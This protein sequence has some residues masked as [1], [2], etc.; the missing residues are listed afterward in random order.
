MSISAKEHVLA[1][2]RWLFQCVFLLVLTVV[3]VGVSGE[4]Q[5]V[6]AQD[7]DDEK[8][9]NKKA[10]N[11]KKSDTESSKKS[12]ITTST[13]SGS[14][15]TT[16]V[17]SKQTTEQDKKTTASSKQTTE[18]DKKTTA[19]SKQTTEQDKKTAVSSKQTTEQDKKTTVSSKQT[20]EQE[21]SSQDPSGK[22]KPPATTS[23]AVRA[24]EISDAE[25]ASVANERTEARVSSPDDVITREEMIKMVELKNS[26]PEDESHFTEFEDSDIAD[27][28]E[29]TISYNAD[30][31]ITSIAKSRPVLEN[32][33]FKQ[34]NESEVSSAN[35]TDGVSRKETRRT[36][37]DDEGNIRVVL[38]TDRAG[39]ET[40]KQFDS[41][42]KQTYQEVRDKDGNPIAI[43][44]DFERNEEI[45]VQNSPSS[46]R[47]TIV[48]GDG[49][50]NDVDSGDEVWKSEESEE[51]G[52]RIVRRNKL[53]SGSANASSN[54]AEEVVEETI[55]ERPDG[56][57]SVRS[58]TRDGVTTT[59][60]YDEDG[61]ITGQTTREEPEGGGD[62]L[63]ST[64]PL[65]LP[66]KRYRAELRAPEKDSQEYEETLYGEETS[67]IKLDTEGNIR[68]TLTENQNGSLTVRE[69]AGDGGLISS[70][71][72]GAKTEDGKPSSSTN[73]LVID[74]RD[75]ESK[76][77]DTF[78]TS[79]VR[80]PFGPNDENGDADS[81]EG[82]DYDTNDVVLRYNTR[83]FRE[84]SK[85]TYMVYTLFAEAYGGSLSTRLAI[86]LPDMTHKSVYDEAGNLT[87]VEGFS[88]DEDGNTTFDSTQFIQSEEDDIGD[89][90][91]SEGDDSDDDG[92]D[93][94]AEAES[95]RPATPVGLNIVVL[96]GQK[97]NVT[98]NGNPVGTEG[99]AT[100]AG[101]DGFLL[102][103]LVNNLK[104]SEHGR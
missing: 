36:A 72:L 17:S 52:T 102:G 104:T 81:N 70:H 46:G 13:A 88:R 43:N 37:Y 93:A 30:E 4:Q 39:N 11:E 54:P 76:A 10:A 58:T 89:I 20:T 9:Q 69:F 1:K 31:V 22:K 45:D 65:K 26:L 82:G 62:P 94:E 47:T 91:Q 32:G 95:I 6:F 5:K 56:T 51:D 12:A 15:T 2:R 78:R 27:W 40:L 64:G 18:Q 101:L 80:D 53:V 75:P 24:G 60:H 66:T 87:Q 44:T 59:T 100:D 57:R 97:P 86:T 67:Q 23:V 74:Q 35:V 48:V 90:N 49:G 34:A 63:D 16:T 103:F 33:K 42:G 19:S 71:T 96:R 98:I 61:N 25:D 83:I 79:K 85:V 21:E 73:D 29:T 38:T 50:E 8:T 77:E 28:A 7:P 68:R 84:G 55:V 41:D 3:L 92:S 99:A 14:T